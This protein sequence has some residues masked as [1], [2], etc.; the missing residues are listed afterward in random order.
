MKV[1]GEE[2]EEEE[3]EGEEVVDVMMERREVEGEDRDLAI[4]RA[5]L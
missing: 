2:G 3:D 1:G 5:L 4:L